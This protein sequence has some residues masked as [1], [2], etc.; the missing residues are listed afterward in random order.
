[1]DYSGGNLVVIYGTSSDTVYPSLEITGL[2]AGR[3]SSELGPVVLLRSG[4]APVDYSSVFP[5]RPSDWGRYGDYFGADVDPCDPSVW[6]AGEYHDAPDRW[7]TYIAN[8]K[9]P[10]ERS[11]ECVPIIEPEIPCLEASCPDNRTSIQ[12]ADRNTTIPSPS[13]P[14]A[15][16]AGGSDVIVTR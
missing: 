13:D 12:P 4:T 7:S 5:D 8:T 2:H 10:E 1:M 15:P 14:S 16:S 3:P 11:V 6:V 9:T